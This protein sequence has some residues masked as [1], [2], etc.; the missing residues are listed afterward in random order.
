MNGHRKSIGYNE[1]MFYVITEYFG[2]QE[3]AIFFLNNI[4]NLKKT[5]PK[6]MGRAHPPKNKIKPLYIF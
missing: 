2:A 1:I 5:T 4:F 6:K 3:V